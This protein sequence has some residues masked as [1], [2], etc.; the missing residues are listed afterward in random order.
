MKY[1]LSILILL[2]GIAFATA[3]DSA[4]SASQRRERNC[5]K[6][7]NEAYRAGDYAKAEAWYREAR[8][9]NP[10]STLAL[11]N[12]ALALERQH[13]TKKQA[14]AQ[15][16]GTTAPASDANTQA[17][18]ETPK[19]LLTKVTELASDKKLLQL[20]FYNLGNLAFNEE[21]Y[22][23]AIDYYKQSLRIDETNLQARQNLRIAQIKLKQQ[24]QNQN[25]NQQ[26]QDQDQEKEEKE[27][28]QQNQQDQQQNQNQQ[29]NQQQNQPQSPQTNGNQTNQNAE[30]ILDAARKREAQTRKDIERRQ[31]SGNT[32]VTVD[33]PW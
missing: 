32:R 25:Q 20:A 11:F 22:A 2:T 15:Q 3:S 28:N 30:Q 29:Q 16:S 9:Y 24:Q 26:N 1:L 13:P 23:S 33:K 31:N 6:S 18:E 8:Q 17:N 14:L 21:D 19:S 10:G 12:L 7:G 5:I 4:S 27:Q